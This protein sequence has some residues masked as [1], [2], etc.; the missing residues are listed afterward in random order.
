MTILV[1]SFQEVHHDLYFKTVCINCSERIA[2][3]QHYNLSWLEDDNRQRLD[4]I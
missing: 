3:E 4:V 1:G 2:I